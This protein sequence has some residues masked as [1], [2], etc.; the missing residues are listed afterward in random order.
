MKPRNKFLEQIKRS[1]DAAQAG[2]EAATAPK[3][4]SEMTEAELD[5]EAERLNRELRASKEQAVEVG[6]QE[7]AGRGSGRLIFPR[8][9]KRP[10]K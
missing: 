4:V 7:A 5:Q 8:R 10:W 1:R 9:K 2:A 6:R 3:P